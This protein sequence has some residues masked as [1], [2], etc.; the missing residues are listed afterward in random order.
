MPGRDRLREL[1]ADP[2]EAQNELEEFMS[3]LHQPEAE[4]MIDN[5]RHWQEEVAPI[6]STVVAG[7]CISF[8]GKLSFMDLIGFFS[9]MT[10]LTKALYLHGR[11]EEQRSLM[12]ARPEEC[13]CQKSS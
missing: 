8:E 5:S 6:L 2:A 10:D 1:L 7:M 13:Q 11:F 3:V 12:F 4:D 9:S